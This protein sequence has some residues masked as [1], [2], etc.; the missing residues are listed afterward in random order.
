MF[1]DSIGMYDEEGRRFWIGNQVIFQETD[2]DCQEPDCTCTE[3]KEGDI[4]VIVYIT[5]HCDER[6]ALDYMQVWLYK[7]CKV[8]RAYKHEVL[9]NRAPDGHFLIG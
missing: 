3:Q 2:C 6:E 9:H 1:F 4:G 5:T 8:V 7:N